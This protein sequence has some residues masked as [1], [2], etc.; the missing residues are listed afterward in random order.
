MATPSPSVLYSALNIVQ[1]RILPRR[2]DF[3]RQAA[4]KAAQVYLQKV[5]TQEAR[6]IEKFRAEEEKTPERIPSDVGSR[7]QPR[8]NSLAREIYHLPVSK[9]IPSL[10]TRNLAKTIFGKSDA[11]REP[12]LR[13]P[14]KN[15]TLPPATKPVFVSSRPYS[16]IE[17]PIYDQYGSHLLAYSSETNR[18]ALVCEEGVFLQ[19]GAL[20]N[21]PGKKRQRLELTGGDNLYTEENK[22]TALAFRTQLVEI[23]DQLVEMEQLLVGTQYGMVNVWN[24]PQGGSPSLEASYR[25]S[26]LPE[27][28]IDERAVFVIH[29]NRGRIF[30]GSKGHMREIDEISKRADNKTLGKIFEFSKCHDPSVPVYEIIGSQDKEWIATGGGDGYVY[31]Y[32]RERLR[33]G[34]RS[35]KA[36][37]LIGGFNDRIRAMAFA[38]NEYNLMIASGSTLA[39]L[40]MQG[41]GAKRKAFGKS[42]VGINSEVSQIY[43]LSNKRVLTTHEDGTFRIHAVETTT[44]K[45][46]QI[47]RIQAHEERITHSHYNPKTGLLTTWSPADGEI[48]TWQLPY[49]S[50][51]QV[52][53]G[54]LLTGPGPK[55][56]IR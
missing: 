7:S 30:V 42:T 14:I 32:R 22:A 47:Q 25:I 45:I 40:R 44:G 52:A 27:D 4:D 6:V 49:I 33:S 39:L 29:S 36:I 11:L 26:E 13:H 2:L 5:E 55:F 35:Y 53:K 43:W 50:K 46:Q 31:F 37:S 24:V 3:D 19:N 21:S 34:E 15:R 20:T 8:I 41:E 23:D 1:P 9:E 12:V 51:K 56:P 17:A 28:T 18:T 54:N 48:K 16:A 38:P 10:H